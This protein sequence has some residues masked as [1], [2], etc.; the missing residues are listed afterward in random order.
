MLISTTELNVAPPG[1][2]EI[3]IKEPIGEQWLAW[4][5][6]FTITHT[7]SGETLL[8]GNIPDQAALYGLLGKIRD[9]NLTLISVNRVEP[10]KD[11]S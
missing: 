10:K 7:E 5:D 4:F 11:Q 1:H 3:L 6:E 9:L 8:S 2:Y